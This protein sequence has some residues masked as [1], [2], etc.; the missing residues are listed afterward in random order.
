M[1][2]MN[3]KNKHLLGLAGLSMIL[4]LNGCGAFSGGGN[5]ALMTLDESQLTMDEARI[6]AAA[7]RSSLEEAYGADAFAVALQD[8]DFEFY[9]K[10]SI[11]RE[12]Q[13]TFT[14]SCLAA[15]E[16]I[17]LSEDDKNSLHEAAQSYLS[18][19]AEGQ[20]KNM[21]I[22]AEDIESAME[23]YVL[24]RRYSEGFRSINGVNSDPD[25][26]RVIRGKEIVVYYKDESDKA[27]AKEEMNHI[28]ELRQ[29]GRSFTSL[30]AHYSQSPEINVQFSR[31]TYGDS[32]YEDAVFS[33][34]EGTCSDILER[35]SD[36]AFVLFY[37]L[38][39]DVEDM[40]RRNE[41]EQIQVKIDTLIDNGID[42]YLASHENSWN[43]QLWNALALTDESC[44][45]SADFYG[46]CESYL[47]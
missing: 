40:T 2:L 28:Y 15:S 30:A 11:A 17:V 44:E 33:V 24:A 32:E 35:T 21:S 23:H 29:N 19:M 42:K 13:R 12:I 45:S 22:Q 38:D 43:S 10:D 41:E 14:L 26:A 8:A 34:A 3:S 7:Q 4:M 18:S 20:E 25:Q 37:C 5:K 31:G 16:G 9:A 39:A 46:L 36:H 6:L 47:S 27:D 1:S